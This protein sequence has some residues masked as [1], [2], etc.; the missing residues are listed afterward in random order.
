MMHLSLTPRT[1]NL[2]TLEDI[3]RQLCIAKSD[4]NYHNKLFHLACA[5]MLARVGPAL[6]HVKLTVD[7]VESGK[8]MTFVAAVAVCASS[9]IQ[10]N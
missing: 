10:A 5:A 3:K 9:S 4:K 7:A 6:V 2:T 1:R 8:A